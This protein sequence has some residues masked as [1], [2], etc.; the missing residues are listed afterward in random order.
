MKNLI[1]KAESLC[2]L[3]NMPYGIDYEQ[4]LNSLVVKPARA[5]LLFSL[6]NFAF[7]KNFVPLP[8]PAKCLDEDGCICFSVTILKKLRSSAA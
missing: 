3:K 2:Y 8:V 1:Q 6:F 5:V 4:I 7:F